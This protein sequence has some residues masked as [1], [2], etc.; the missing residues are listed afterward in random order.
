MLGATQRPDGWWTVYFDFAHNSVTHRDY[1]TLSPIEY[2]SM[3]ESQIKE[4]RQERFAAWVKS[5]VK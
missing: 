3:T 1:I 5:L 4:L 2:V